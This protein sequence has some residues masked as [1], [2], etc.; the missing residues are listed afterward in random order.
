[1]AAM[2]IKPTDALNALADRID[3]SRF[4]VRLVEYRKR[5][6]LRVVSLGAT[7]LTDTIVAHLDGDRVYFAWSWGEVV[8]S[9]DD[10][11]TVGQKVMRVLDIHESPIAPN[12]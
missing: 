8:G 11:D 1:M 4:S 10:L 3:A 5:P 12:T 9:A 7:A 6:A 2:S